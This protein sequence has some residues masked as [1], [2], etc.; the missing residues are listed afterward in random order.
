M[1]Y[2]AG[3]YRTAEM[4]RQPQLSRGADG[5]YRP[6][7]EAPAPQL[8]DVSRPGPEFATYTRPPYGW[9]NIDDDHF[10]HSMFTLARNLL[11]FARPAMGLHPALR[12]IDWPWRLMEWLS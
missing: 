4:R 7:S 11:K 3:G 9:A 2:P 8:P 10:N 12:L 1:S 6:P 5:V